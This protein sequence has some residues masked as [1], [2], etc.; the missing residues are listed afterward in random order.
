[1]SPIIIFLLLYLKF[2]GW[3]NKRIKKDEAIRNSKATFGWWDMIK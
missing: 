3:N 1:M 2:G